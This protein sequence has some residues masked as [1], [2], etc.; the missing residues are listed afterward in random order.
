MKNFVSKDKLS[1]KAKREL[2]L[3]Q[4]KVWPCNTVTRCPKDAKAY[5]RNNVRKMSLH[6]I[7]SEYCSDYMLISP[8]YSL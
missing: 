4:R 3:R 2:D 5:D 6:L 8:V 1:K 7:D